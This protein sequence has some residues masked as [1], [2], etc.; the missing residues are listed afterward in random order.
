M[1]PTLVIGDVHGCVDELDALLHRHAGERDVVFVGDLVAKGPDSRGVVAR[2][3]KLEALAVRGNH[4]AH[5]LRA[6]EAM[7]KGEP[8]PQLRPQHREV[9]DTLED[10]D[11]AY[12]AALPDW[13][14][15]PAFDVLV[16]HAGLVPGVAPAVQS[17]NDLINMRSIRP[18]GSASKRIEDGVPW[19]SVWPGP[20]HVLFGHDAVRGLQRHPFAT[21]LDTGCVYGKALTAMLLPE[22]EL[23]SVPAE[24]VWFDPHGEDA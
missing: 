13:L 19:A 12:L 14:E 4:E 9:V 23:V 5:V 21:G 17:P 7:E 16:V 10:D 20:Q 3:R 1:Q 18:D 24:R 6:R 22:M 15:L 2:A 8:T 11:W